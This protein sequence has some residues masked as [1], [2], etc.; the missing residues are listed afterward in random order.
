MSDNFPI[1]DPS[2]VPPEEPLPVTPQQRR[3]VEEYLIDPSNQTK[4]AIRA[5]YSII[6]AKSQASQLMRHT[7]IKALIEEAQAE[8]AHKMGITQD[9]VLQELAL[10]AF[11]NVKDVMT[12]NE[13]GD[14]VIDL[15]NMKREVAA[16][17]GEVSIS[18]KGG[19]NKTRTAKIRMNDKLTALEK[20][21]KHL[22]MFVEK[23]EHTGKLTLEQLVQ[24]SMTEKE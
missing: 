16:A 1:K 18:T 19:V 10:I 8:R 20:I 3:F 21:G 17:L 9:R 12:I 23:V 4:A 14:T 13:E 22:G 11:A 2:L 7:G 6:S 15:N 24:A 5:G